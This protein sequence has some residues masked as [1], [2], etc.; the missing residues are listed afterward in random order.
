MPVVAGIYF[1]FYHRA[2][3]TSPS[4]DIFVAGDFNGADEVKELPSNSGIYLT[5]PL[6]PNWN[7]YGLG[8]PGTGNIIQY[9]IF[10][11]V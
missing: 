2:T 6:T 4:V 1:Y 9:L 10:K 3:L 5:A 8:S 7:F 11:L